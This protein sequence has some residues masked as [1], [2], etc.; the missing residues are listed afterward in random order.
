WGA[1]APVIS[2]RT[3][4]ALSLVQENENGHLYDLERLEQFYHALDKTLDSPAHARQIA[5]NGHLL[6]KQEYD[7]L[8]LT[9]RM[10]DLY[11]ELI[12]EKA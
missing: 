6:A 2:T 7:T 10:K 4:G 1:K 11:E 12:R 5:E 9:R 8:L 3:S